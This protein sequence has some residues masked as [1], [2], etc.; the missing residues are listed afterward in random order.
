MAGKR[1]FLR[2]RLRR[3]SLRPWLPGV[4]LVLAACPPAALAATA[5]SGWDPPRDLSNG[6]SAP[7][8]PAATAGL[9]ARGNA[10]VL[11]HAA[12]GVESVVRAAG[13]GFGAAHAIAGSHFSMG[14]LRPQLAFDAHGAALAVW[15]YFE[16]HPRFVE[17]GYAVDY[18]FGLRVAGR[19]PRGSFGRAQTLTDK[20]DAD[21]SADV[22]FDPAGTAVVIWTDDAGMHAAARP[23]G[24][25]RFS[26]AQVISQTQADPQ[27]SIGARGSAVAAWAA[28]RRRSWSV[29]A[30]VADGA[31]GFGRAQKL[32]ISGLGD[33]KPVVAIDGRSAV[34]AA[35]ARDGRVMA[36]TCSAAGRCGRA[37]A[38]SRAGQKAS[39]PRV[40]VAADGSAVVAWHSSAGV[41][42]ALRHGHRAFAPA[43]V[44]SSLP[45]GGTATDLAVAVGARG[46]SAALWTVHRS[47][48]DTVVAATRRAHHRFG[49]AHALTARVASAGWSDPQVVVDRSGDVLA[50]WG[51]AIGGHPSIQAAAY[52]RPR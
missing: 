51:A 36:A 38:L 35:W 6:A 16:P 5:H 23:A 10:I 32:P 14:D 21:P 25:R 15:S 34:T 31:A 3:W 18:T 30:A 47:D 7:V 2:R 17:D 28:E 42:A 9:D 48:G 29:T 46:D 24:K 4:A 41:S 43:V 39:G 45:N 40:A 13:H 19:G 1:S 44:L 37:Q 52:N 49:H 8:S 22:A 11:W 12:P 20:L 26:R 33:A 50:V 27:V